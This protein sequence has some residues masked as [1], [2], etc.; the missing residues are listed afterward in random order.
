MTHCEKIFQKNVSRETNEQNMKGLFRLCSIVSRETIEHNLKIFSHFRY[1]AD[2]F[3]VAGQICGGRG[4]FMIKSDYSLQ[5]D[6]RF[7]FSPQDAP[8]SR[9]ER[10]RDRCGGYITYP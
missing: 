4:Y 5:T 6:G 9:S 3:F 10:F 7:V 8:P 1:V 2:F